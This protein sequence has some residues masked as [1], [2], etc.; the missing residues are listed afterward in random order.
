MYPYVTVCAPAQGCPLQNVAHWL[1]DIGRTSPAAL[2]TARYW[3]LQATLAERQGRSNAAVID[4]YEQ[5]V[6]HR[7]VV[8]DH[9]VCGV[10]DVYE[11][12]VR[13]RA[14]VSQV[15]KRRVGGEKVDV[16]SIIFPCFKR[17]TR[18]MYT[19]YSV[20]VCLVNVW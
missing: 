20:H 5:A 1:D 3:V 7:A 18:T 9:A 4:V 2:N 13:H 12:A 6:R 16:A 8:S 14:V 19:M 11:Q 15:R 10:I 17:D